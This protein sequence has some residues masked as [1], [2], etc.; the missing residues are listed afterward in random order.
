MTFFLNKHRLGA[1]ASVVTSLV[2]VSGC[3][4]A[5]VNDN[6]GAGSYPGPSVP[7]YRSFERVNAPYE[8]DSNQSPSPPPVPPAEI[9]IP[10]HSDPEVVPPSPST[11]RSRW[12]LRPSAFK[13]PAFNRSSNTV[14]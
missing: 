9:Q 7:F 14:D 5:S 1:M 13:R 2:L 11:Q 12:N 4:S 3:R 6:V 10:G 8:G